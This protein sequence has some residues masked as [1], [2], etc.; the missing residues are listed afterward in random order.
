MAF[1]SWVLPV[2]GRR[3]ARRRNWW[4]WPVGLVLAGV[5]L[6][7][8]G[9]EPARTQRFDHCD[10]ALDCLGQFRDEL[11]ERFGDDPFEFT[12]R[13][14]DSWIDQCTTVGRSLRV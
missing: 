13:P 3:C 4:A 6:R 9:P 14:G 1:A 7:A 10:S 11:V 8:I 2:G 12:D 5:Q